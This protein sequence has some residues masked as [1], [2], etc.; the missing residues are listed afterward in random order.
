[1]KY[2]KIRTKIYYLISDSKRYGTLPFAGIA[3][4][5]FISKSILD[6]LQKIEM[7][8][9]NEVENFYLSINTISKKI[10][11]D[12]YRSRLNKKYKKFL[13]NY[14][15]LRTSTYS[16]L[17]KNYKEKYNNS[18]IAIILIRTIIFFCFFVNP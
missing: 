15:H 16:I 12:Y 5:A 18:D 3:R 2:I 7:I 4:C 14:G 9:S 11:K 17:T 6:S 8:K 13:D 10:N 1:M